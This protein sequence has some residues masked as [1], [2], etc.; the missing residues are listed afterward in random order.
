MSMQACRWQNFVN[1]AAAL[2]CRL[3]FIQ[4]PRCTP[5]NETSSSPAPEQ[6]IPS[7]TSSLYAMLDVLAYS[8]PRLDPCRAISDSCP[9][10]VLG[11]RFSAFSI[12]YPHRRQCVLV[13]ASFLGRLFPAP[14][15]HC[16]VKAQPGCVLSPVLH[17]G[18]LSSASQP[19]VTS[20][21]PMHPRI[22]VLV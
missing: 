6:Q 18:R 13:S 9:I 21:L 1:P 15:L 10:L 3:P 19:L 4:A 17:L 5:E 20:R 11:R 2:H 22:R 14:R 8:R 16:Y 12:L 7:P